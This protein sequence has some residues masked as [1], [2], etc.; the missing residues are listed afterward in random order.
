MENMESAVVL[1]GIIV[2]VLAVTA[3]MG[4]RQRL[5][6]QKW[7]FRKL[8]GEYGKVPKKEMSPERFANVPAYFRKHARA[9]QIDDITWNDLDMDLIYH[10]IDNTRSSSGEEY[11]YYAL[12]SPAL[13][14][15]D[16]PIRDDSVDLLAKQ[17]DLRLAIE[18]EL[19][20][21]GTT[22]KYS[23]Y[24][25]LS[26]LDQLG[27]RSSVKH[28]ISFCLPIAA[29]I[30]IIFNAQWGLMLLI[31]AL[32]FNI[33]TYL[34]EKREIEPFIVTF[35]Y[36]LR[37]MDSAKQMQ[38]LLQK[39]TVASDIWAEDL[40][41][42]KESGAALRSFARGSWMIVSSGDGSN[43]LDLVFDYLRMMFHID[44]LQFNHMLKSVREH[45]ED[46]DTMVTVIGRL[47]AEISVAS[48]R[49]SL[50]YQCRPEFQRDCGAGLHLQKLYHPLLDHPVPNDIDAS[51][52][53]LLTGSNASGKSTFLKAVALAALLSQTIG[54][55]AAE[56]Y[57]ASRFRIYSSMALRDNL[58]NGESYYIVEIK[59]L[60][61][62]ADAAN[63]SYPVLCFVDEVLRGTN[64]IERIAASSEILAALARKNVLCFAA[65]HDI[66]L[67]KLLSADYSNY[68]FEEEL[69]DNDV[70][71]SY[72]L[73]KGPA[74]TRNAI[75][76][77]GMVGFDKKLTDDASARAKR[78]ETTG[79]W[80]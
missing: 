28:L 15:E 37:L 3:V 30:V 76:L 50:P 23:M 49:E 44:L 24:D 14:K 67:T 58:V 64:T 74:T 75:S 51:K 57:E 53:V 54:V 59:S 68:H 19:Y 48:F 70:T 27:D 56:R 6:H 35:R 38:A 21:L 5:L 26:L 36:V 32:V 46:I 39:N 73:H 31:A 41:L 33:S 9:H 55:C 60:K 62:I 29:L 47:D 77:L 78:F 16:T 79:E 45:R 80:K 66:E 20:H 8:T 12:R 11:L 18:K 52:S 72:E 69:K 40:Q 10:R 25:Y 65:T 43:P 7:L 1:I 22:G 63:E 13:T 17:A 4:L 42:L 34:R 2:S 71:F 61:R